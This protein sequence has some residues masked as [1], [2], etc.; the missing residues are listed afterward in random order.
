MT[1]IY[2]HWRKSRLK[3]NPRGI[4]YIVSSV[5]GG[6]KTTLISLLLEKHPDIHFSISVT[7]RAVRPGDEPGKNY[8][9]VTRDEFERL[10]EHDYFLEWALV[11]DN[12]YGTS[13][14][15]IEKEIRK[16]YKIILDI[17]VQGFKIIKSKIQTV[18]SIFILPPSEEIWIQRLKNRV[19]E[20]RIRNGRRELLLAGEYDYRIV[21]DKLEDSLAQLE[22]ILF[23]ESKQEKKSPSNE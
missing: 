15:Y 9:F 22:N 5:A 8:Q 1:I 2:P 4:L 7:S 11:H 21:N 12:Y 19:I 23:G 14:R 20:R 18:K 6:G 3:V 10:I 17:D 13:K 16:G